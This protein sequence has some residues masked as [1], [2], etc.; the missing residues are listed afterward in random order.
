MNTALIDKIIIKTAELSQQEYNPFDLK[1]DYAEAI[2]Y[3]ST[4]IGKFLDHLIEK[5][6]KFNLA[7]LKN[8]LPSE[9]MFEL[10]K[11][12]NFPILV[13]SEQ[14]EGE[15]TPFIIHK[16]KNDKVLF[17]SFKTES[18]VAIHNT[19]VFYDSL[20]VYEDA[21]DPQLNG[22]V[23]FLT[24]VPLKYIVSDY[25]FK[26]EKDKKKLTPLRRLYR[27]MYS[28][29][30]DIG[31]IY[32]YAIVVGLISLSLPLG[33]QATISLISGGMI[34][35]SVVVLIALVIVGVLVGGSLQVMQISLVEV[36]Q[37][38]VFAKASFEI[39]FRITKIKMESLEKYYPPELMNRFFDV[40]TIQKGLPKLFVDITG[41]VIQIIFGLILLSLYHPF[42][43]MFSI[44]LVLF[45]TMIFYFTGSRGLETSIKESSY[46]YKIAYWL[47]E[48]AR[49][50]YAFKQAG[51]TNLPMQQMDNLVNS[52]LYHRREHFK[53]LIT[54][55]INI[56]AFKTLITGGLLIL[57]TI[58]V[59]DRQITLG[60]FVA[61]E[62]I[63]ILVV[64]SVEKL[65]VSLDT[66][67][68]LLTGVEKVATIT[69]LPIERQSGLRINLTENEKGLHLRAKELKYRYKGNDNY[70]LKNV[71]F[72]IT[73]GE[74][75]CIAGP[76]DSGKHTL[77]KV[78]TGFLSDYEG[79]ITINGLSLHDLNL[80]SLRDVVNKHLTFDEI[81]DGTIL[82]NIAMGRS[83]I[84]HSDVIWAIESVGLT[85]YIASLPKGFSTHIGFSGKKLSSGIVAKLLLARSVSSRP[86]LL[87]VNDFSEH[88]PK[89]EKLKILSFLQEKSNGWTLIILSVSDDPLLLSSCDKILLMSKGEVMAEGSYEKLLSNPI[90]QS[91]IFKGR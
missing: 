75:V 20:V 51:N 46:K 28:E 8:H 80:A 37:Q 88:I 58:L 7:F 78:L 69:D 11:S 59:V 23:I 43:L 34:F 86:K 71:N 40:I 17:Y 68:D 19:N 64:G 61:S 2:S 87:I 79:L 45:V 18:D 65:I 3:K 73:P 31:Y 77:V 56:V 53:V 83:N 90:F 63:I 84:H 50:V 44:F 54:Q 12:S 66:V 29:R 82:D 70:T 33:I 39:A 6:H 30:K 91:L 14:T 85:D 72:E 47:E 49:T 74:S 55:F 9:H 52:Y 67:Y 36:L 57:G 5:S 10:V 48:L 27:L 1:D 21:A 22:E 38:R 81:F 62:V 13:F 41:A 76:N 15:I 42:F 26:D 89:N 32:I 25:Y 16:D 24:V 35:S 4:Q 60:Q